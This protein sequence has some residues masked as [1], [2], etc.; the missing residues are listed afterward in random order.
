MSTRGRPRSFDRDKALQA[1][2][3]VFWEQ[4]FEGASMAALTRAMGINAPSLYGCFGSKEEL[5]EEA[6]TRYQD[7]ENVRVRALLEQ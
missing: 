1:A 2:I 7:E 3:T 5:F 4:G 6:V